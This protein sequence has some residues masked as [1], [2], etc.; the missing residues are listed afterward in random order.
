[1]CSKYNFVATC[2]VITHKNETEV[3]HN[4]N[5]FFFTIAIIPIADVLEKSI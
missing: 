5:S 3:S 2:I 1:M 4:T